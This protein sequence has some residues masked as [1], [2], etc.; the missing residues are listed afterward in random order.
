MPFRLK[1]EISVWQ[2]E[3]PN[4]GNISNDSDFAKRETC[5]FDVFQKTLLQA[6]KRK[7]RKLTDHGKQLLP[8]ALT[9]NVIVSYVKERITME[10]D[11]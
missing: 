7:S 2:H 9:L 8:R 6:V 11:M 5:S 10:N 3:M 4:Y 1:P